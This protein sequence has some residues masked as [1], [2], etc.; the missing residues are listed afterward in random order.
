MRQGKGEFPSDV[1]PPQKG[2]SRKNQGPLARG[3]RQLHRY[4]RVFSI[5]LVGISSYPHTK[6]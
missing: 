5:I 2:R 1:I 6:K 3:P 4:G